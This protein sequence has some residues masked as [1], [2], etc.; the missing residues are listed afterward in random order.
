MPVVT[1]LVAVLLAACSPAGREQP[2]AAPSPERI[3]TLA[4]HLAEL[5]YAAGA[6]SRLVGVSAYSNHPA[7]VGRLP[8]VGDA[9]AVDQEQLALLAPDLLLAWQSGTPAHVVDELRARGFRVEV[10]VTRGLADVAAALRR[11]GELTGDPAPAEAAARRYEQALDELRARRPGVEPLR[12]FYQVSARPLYTVNGEHYISELIELCGGVNVFAGLG[13]LAP[14]VGEEAVLAR[15]PE[16][17][18]AAGG[19]PGDIFRA[20]LRWPALAA[21]RYGNRFVVDADLAGRASPRLPEAGRQLCARL[22]DAR[23]RRA[24]ARAQSD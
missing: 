21:N 4:P 22:D 20:W 9:F 16:V 14:T 24:R 2:A 7:E 12:V 5:V 3:V 8:V 10:L 1:L 6:G 11:I 18:L 15:D 13:V 23:V 17:L 19:D